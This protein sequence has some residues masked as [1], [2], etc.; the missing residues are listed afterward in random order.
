LSGG[1]TVI[2]ATGTDHQIFTI[3]VVQGT[4]RIFRAFVGS[5]VKVSGTGT[6]L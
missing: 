5:P 2:T 1:A 4:P 3:T 6:I